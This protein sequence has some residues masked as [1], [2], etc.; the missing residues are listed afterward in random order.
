MINLS[1]GTESSRSSPVLERAIDDVRDEGVMVVVSA[2]NR[3]SSLPQYPGNADGV[4]SVTCL[5]PEG[6]TI[7]G[8]ANWGLWVDVAARGAQLVGPGAGRLCD[9]VGDLDGRAPGLGAARADPRAC[10]RAQ[11]EEPTRRGD[12]DPLPIS[13]HTIRHGAVD[14]EAS[15]QYAMDDD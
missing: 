1:F 5:D 9:L 12:Q 10:A 4:L 15:M 3:G 13:I 8:Y 7:S 14:I 2:G 6:A 11:P